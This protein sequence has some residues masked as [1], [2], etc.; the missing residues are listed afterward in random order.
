MV[1]KAAIIP[2]DINPNNK[3]NTGL[4]SQTVNRLKKDLLGISD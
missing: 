2:G 3:S 4:S 1:Q